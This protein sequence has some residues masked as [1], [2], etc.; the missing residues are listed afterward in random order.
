M[1]LNRSGDS[2]IQK[3]IIACLEISFLQM[4]NNVQHSKNYFTVC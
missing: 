3:S 4:D 1:K 2:I